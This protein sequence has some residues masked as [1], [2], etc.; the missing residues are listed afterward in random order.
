MP[1]RKSQKDDYTSPAAYRP[2]SLLATLGRMLESLMAYRLAFLAEQ[3]S[4]LL[5]NHFGRLKQRTTVDALLVLQEKIYQAWKDRKVLSLIT[6][7]VKG[8]FSGVAIEELIDRLQKRRVPEKMVSWISNFCRNRKAIVTVNGETSITTALEQA[9]LPQGSPL[10]PIL[11]LFFNSDLVQGVINKNKGSIAFIDDF[12]TWVVSP[13]I[14]ENLKK[15]SNTVIPHVETWAH[16][17]TTVFNSQKTVFTHCTRTASKIICIEAS[18]PLVIL[19]ASV[20]PSSQ[21]KILGVVLD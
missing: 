16:T 15:I 7:D 18:E 13:T 3:Y 21:V 12:T 9:G 4:L 8:A 20:P 5:Y 14:A 1:L 2:I 19:R 10:S 17:S 6:F 11:Y